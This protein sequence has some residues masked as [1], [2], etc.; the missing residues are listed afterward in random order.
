MQLFNMQEF[1]TNIFAEVSRNYMKD[2][3]VLNIQS[4]F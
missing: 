3:G 2:T 1:S 4:L